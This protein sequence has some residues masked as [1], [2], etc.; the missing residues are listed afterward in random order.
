MK[1]LKILGL[2]VVAAMAVV[3]ICGAGSASATAFCTT[4]VSPCPTGERWLAGTSLTGSI[5]GSST[6]EAKSTP[7]D[8][9]TVSTL[10]GKTISNGSSF[11][12]ITLKLEE[13]TFLNCVSKITVLTVGELQIHWI[14]GTNN[15]TITARGI[16][17]EISG[18]LGSCEWTFGSEWTD[19]GKIYGG[20]PATIEWSAPMPWCGF[21]AVTGAYSVTA[22]KPL[23]VVAA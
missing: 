3:A 6:W 14:S 11:E 16:T 10:K 9:C 21:T 12:T 5:L 18:G 20:N 7:L 4:P 2:A 22:P 1:H 23:Y 17:G 8:T 13:L 15:G 19:I